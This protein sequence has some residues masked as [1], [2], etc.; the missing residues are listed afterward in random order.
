MLMLTSVPGI[1]S[2]AVP[3][4]CLPGA[5][6]YRLPVLRAWDKA[7]TR[8]ES[9]TGLPIPQGITVT[10]CNGRAQFRR[11]VQGVPKWAAGVALCRDRSIVVD[12]AAWS[13]FGQN[14]ACT[15]AHELCHLAVA[16][17]ATGPGRAFP[18]WFG[19]GLACWASGA[20][21]LGDFGEADLAAAFD[22]LPALASIESRFPDREQDVAL[23]YLTSERFVGY[24]A[25]RFGDETVLA[26][27]AKTL[28]RRSFR[29][30]FESLYNRPVEAVELQWRKELK[31][32]TPPVWALLRSLNAF[33]VMAVLAVV[34]F[35]MTKLRNRRI[36]RAWDQEGFG[37]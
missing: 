33:A 27:V 23:A 26:L 22:Q 34:A 9:R 5:E 24:L 7:K 36:R 30:A 19:E 28:V 29:S 2:A 15:L 14:A 35:A 8:V 20:S 16:A 6:R 11:T 31:Q 10:L 32:S 37:P 13:Q 18:K 12:G 25:D 17:A 21:H 4:R 3:V 1:G